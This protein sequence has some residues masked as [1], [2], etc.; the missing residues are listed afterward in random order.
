MLTTS[1]SAG[2]GSVAIVTVS[3]LTGGST[4][5]GNYATLFYMEN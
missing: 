2:T 1:T 3:A 4:T 5:G